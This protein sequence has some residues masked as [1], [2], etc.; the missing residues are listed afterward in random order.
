MFYSGCFQ[1]WNYSHQNY[2]TFWV[3]TGEA[4]VN[5]YYLLD[6]SAAQGSF[7]CIWCY[8]KGRVICLC[9]HLR[10]LLTLPW[11]WHIEINHFSGDLESNLKSTV[12]TS[13]DFN[14]CQM[15][16]GFL[17]WG[18]RLCFRLLIFFSPRDLLT[19]VF[20]GGGGNRDFTFLTM[21]SLILHLFSINF[22][23]RAFSH[24]QLSGI[25]HLCYGF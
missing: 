13:V 11:R 20:Q 17:G 25:Y 21:M 24:C 6:S 19:S 10:C 3:F 8:L 12:F 18:H 15:W 4:K 23:W 14:G 2:I 16:P 7:S 22:L 9:F 5:W 1:H